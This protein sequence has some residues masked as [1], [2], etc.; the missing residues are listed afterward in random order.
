VEGT[1]SITV[2]EVSG[3][4]Y[5]GVDTHEDSIHV[6][7]ISSRGHNLADQ[8]FPTTPAGYRRAL[9]FIASHGDPIAI[10]I[11]GTSSYGVGITAAAIDEG[12]LS[13][14]PSGP[15]GPSDAAW[16]SPTRSTPTRPPALHWA[17][18]AS[19]QPGT[20]PRSR[21]SERWTTPA[22]QR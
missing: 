1:S 14:R 10:G 18:T 12:L 20:Q 7:V 2:E 5:G 15:N 9:A 21:A 4:V 19:P 22:G 3:Q 17:T 16:A 6:A 11:E 8:E 13:L